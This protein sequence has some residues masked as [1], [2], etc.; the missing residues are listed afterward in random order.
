MN[1]VHGEFDFLEDVQHL[2]AH[3]ARGADHGHPVTHRN[4][5]NSA[6]AS[7]TLPA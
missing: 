4:L 1:A 7:R 5:L 6:D 3:V 2:T